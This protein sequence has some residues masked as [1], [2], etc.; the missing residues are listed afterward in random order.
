MADASVDSIEINVSSNVSKNRPIGS[1]E[2]DATFKVKVDAEGC[3]AILVKLMARHRLWRDEI[4]KLLC[5]K[6]VLLLLLQGQEEKTFFINGGGPA[7][8]GPAAT[9]PAGAT[10]LA[11]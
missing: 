9:E 10:T 8:P 4:C 7:V 2:F 5:W 1:N 3:Y 11:P 6:Q